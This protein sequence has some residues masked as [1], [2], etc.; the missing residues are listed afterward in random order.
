[1]QQ[2]ELPHSSVS[3]AAVGVD[4]VVAVAEAGVAAAAAVDDAWDQH[5]LPNSL[6]CWMK[7]TTLSFAAK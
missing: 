4:V 7:L 5:D 1:M 2:V 3:F 6:Q